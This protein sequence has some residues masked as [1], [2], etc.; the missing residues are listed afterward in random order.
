MEIIR[1]KE[2]E[3]ILP[4]GTDSELELKGFC[5]HHTDFHHF[6]NFQNLDVAFGHCSLSH[7]WELSCRCFCENML[8]QPSSS[9][10]E[11]SNLE[12]RR[13]RFSWG[14]ILKLD[15]YYDDLKSVRSNVFE[16]FF[17]IFTDKRKTFF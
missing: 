3:I 12:E 6:G 9:K 11:L 1:V 5:P 17:L 8:Y 16:C 10:T 14:E 13:D 4:I 7:I 2:N 15:A